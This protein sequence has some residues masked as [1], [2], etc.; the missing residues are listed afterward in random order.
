MKRI[1]L[2]IIIVLLTGTGAFASHEGFGIGV[3]N[4]YSWN[5]F[6]DYNNFGASLKFS[7]PS[8]FWGF[9]F[10]QVRSQYYGLGIT[11]DVY[12]IDNIFISRQISGDDG[13]YNFNLGWYFGIGA[14][15][16]MRCYDGNLGM[17]AGGRLPIGLSWY[18]ARPIEFYLSLIPQ[19]GI[20]LQN[21]SH[22]NGGF[23]VDVGLRLWFL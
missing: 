22:F 7:G 3:V 8:V 17:D 2:L 18:I 6:L 14:F 1:W 15:M 11:A 5:S 23:G 4:H 21:G 10:H 13:E 9:Y 16:N 20:A 19:I 12:L